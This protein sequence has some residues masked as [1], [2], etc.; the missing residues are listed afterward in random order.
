M[1]AQKFSGAVMSTDPEDTHRA[2]AAKEAAAGPRM[3][4]ASLRSILKLAF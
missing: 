3:D 4:V 2:A 1:L